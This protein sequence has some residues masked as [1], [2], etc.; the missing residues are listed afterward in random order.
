M[1]QHIV[2]QSVDFSTG[3]QK[4]Y[5]KESCWELLYRIW[6]L[7]AVNTYALCLM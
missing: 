4:V 5:I 1:N 6:E 3:L 2:L 7:H